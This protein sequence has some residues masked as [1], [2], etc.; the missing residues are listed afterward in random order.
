M[1][2]VVHNLGIDA[3]HVLFG[4]L[5]GPGRWETE[6]GVELVNT[7]CLGGGSRLGFAR[8]LCLGATMTGPPR[9]QS[10]L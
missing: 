5:H 3:R 8:N 6:S 1:D 2:Q 4:H 10:V 7:G 9:L